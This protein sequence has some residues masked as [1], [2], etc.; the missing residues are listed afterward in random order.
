MERACWRIL[1][2]I[3]NA[4]LYNTNDQIFSNVDINVFLPNATSKIQPMDG[5]I[6]VVF[7]QHYQHFY[8]QNVPEWDE[9]N[10]INLYK[11]NQ[12]LAMWWSLVAWVKLSPITIQNYFRHI[13]LFKQ[14]P[15]VAK[16]PDK[17][18]I[19][20]E[21]VGLI[22]G[23]P[24]WNSISIQNLLNPIKVKSA[25]IEV[26]DH[27]IVELVC[28]QVEGDKGLDNILEEDNVP[29][30]FM[31]IK[32]LQSLFVVISMLNVGDVD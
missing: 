3:D 23:L 9:Q 6:I 2:L 14:A 18:T 5:G 15:K 28:H 16:I 7:K 31:G 22:W 11:V 20:E 21:L 26:D 17:E 1:L 10:E 13:R 19:K 32:K 27:K 8:L 29:W 4:P 24:L 25:H 12:L 30:L